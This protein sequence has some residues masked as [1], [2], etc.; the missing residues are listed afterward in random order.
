MNPLETRRL[1]LRTLTPKDA[2][3]L[4]DFDVRNRDFLAAWEPRRDELYFT[5]TRALAAVKADA[6]TAH[7]DT[8]Y[9]WHLFLKDDPGRIVGSVGLSN[10]VHGAFLSTHLGYRLDGTMTGQGLMTEALR[11]VIGQAFSNLGLHRIEANV[12]PRNAA[13]LRVLARLGFE[14]EGLSKRYLRIAGTWE[15]HV[16]HVLLNREVE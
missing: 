2:P 14:Q 6:R 4:L 15:D 3:L 10:I 5:L 11:E 13:S 8:G 9:R 12:M 1:I 16:R 7:R